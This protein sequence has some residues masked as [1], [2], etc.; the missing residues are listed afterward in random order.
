LNALQKEY[1]EK[2]A[3]LEVLADSLN[4][5]KKKANIRYD[6]D[7]NI[8]GDE[9]VRLMDQIVKKLTLNVNEMLSIT[10]QFKVSLSEKLTEIHVIE[11][12]AVAEK[13]SKPVRWLIV[14]A[15]ALGSFAASTVV[16]VI[17]EILRNARDR[18]LPLDSPE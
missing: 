18:H 13:K 8:I 16:V 3:L 11:D 1:D 14:M 7:G 17:I 9:K 12:A 10:N 4:V 2:K 15:T 5:M 6:K